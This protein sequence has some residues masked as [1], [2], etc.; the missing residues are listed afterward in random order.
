MPIV[1][2]LAVVPQLSLRWRHA[3]PRTPATKSKVRLP[4]RVLDMLLDRVEIA[5]ETGRLELVEQP[6]D[7]PLAAG[8]ALDTITYGELLAVLFAEEYEP[9]P[10]GPPT[11]TAP[12]S[13]E[14]IAAYQRRARLGQPVKHAG[15]ATPGLRNDRLAITGSRSANGA[16]WDVHG[17]H[18]EEEEEEL[19]A[20][21]LSDRDL[22][23]LRRR[24]R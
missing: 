2:A 11:D 24:R 4:R 12:K 16:G 8:P 18:V 14:R 19:P 13:D 1:T 20:E 5:V 10:P 21:L 3:R 15:D 22:A 6:A 7:V 23:A 17:W 9:A